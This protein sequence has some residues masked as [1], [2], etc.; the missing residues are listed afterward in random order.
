MKE[1]KSSIVQTSGPWQSSR[2]DNIHAIVV[3][4]DW[5]RVVGCKGRI[6]AVLIVVPFYFK[7][8]SLDETAH[9]TLM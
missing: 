2:G 9:C 1:G 6:I 8:L 5:L 3:P 7:N 4:K